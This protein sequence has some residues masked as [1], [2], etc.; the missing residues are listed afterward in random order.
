MLK[1]SQ[2]LKKILASILLSIILFT[3]LQPVIL[4]ANQVISGSGNST[5]IARQYASKVRTT[6]VG[7][8]V[9]NG[10]I[11]RR[12]IMSDK[13][14]AFGNGDGIIVFCAQLNVPFATRYKL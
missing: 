3:T 4:A 6:D 8:N 10:I 1:F 9:E 5:F 11:A 12:L 7:N 13:G 14:W 2:K